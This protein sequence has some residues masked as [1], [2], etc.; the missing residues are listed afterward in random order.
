MCDAVRERAGKAGERE[1]GGEMKEKRDC[2]SSS[3]VLRSIGATPSR[4]RE[5][6]EKQ[7][8]SFSLPLF[9]VQNNE[10]AGSETHVRIMVSPSRVLFV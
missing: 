8:R 4:E 1:R 2:S 7:W 5:R 6:E 10:I 9:L 3:R